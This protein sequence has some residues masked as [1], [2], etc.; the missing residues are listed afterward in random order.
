MAGGAPFTNLDPPTAADLQRSGFDLHELDQ[1]MEHLLTYI[2]I[3]LIPNFPV[4]DDRR[5]TA[6][7][8]PD[9]LDRISR[10]PSPDAARTAALSSRWRT[11][12]RSA[13]PDLIDAHLRP[14]DYFWPPAP[15]NSPA[16][17]ATVSRILEAHPGPFRRVHLVCSH[18]N[19]YQPQLARWLQL[20][21]AK[22]VQDLVL[23]NRPWP[24]DVPLPGALF[25][26]NTLVR[27]YIGLWKLPDTARLGRYRTF[28]H[29]R[30]LGIC[31]VVMGE[32]D[33]DSI[34]ARCPVLEI[35]SIQ[36]SSK[37]L[38]LRLVSQSLRCVQICSSVVENIAVV[39]A[40]SLERLILHG[41]RDMP[42]GLSSRVRILDAPKLRALGVLEPTNHVLEIG[43]K[44]I[45]AGIKTNTSTIL[46]SVK[47]LSLN[48]RFGVRSEAEMVPTFLKCF[49]NVKRLHIMNGRNY[50]VPNIFHLGVSNDNISGLATVLQ[51]LQLMPFRASRSPMFRVTTNV[52]GPL[53]LL[54]F[55]FCTI[56]A[57]EPTSTTRARVSFA[58]AFSSTSRDPMRSETENSCLLCFREVA[59]VPHEGGSL[60]MMPPATNLSGSRSP[61]GLPLVAA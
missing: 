57:A 40:P 54:K 26:V 13:Q 43:D 6:L 50:T 49:P 36:G 48:V 5:L 56:W 52:A 51:L 12:W 45:R 34:V 22:G 28:P 17:T 21:A 58:L 27:L 44:I 2:C 59:K 53:L 61:S 39:K 25:A 47:I 8:A 19:G 38:R 46:T 60:A 14:D 33:V 15:A 37:G 31:C 35:L 42:F 11:I 3:N 29:L 10:L 32:G 18:M 9:G 4:P 16:I 7:P 55:F 1:A 23:V 20:L 24:C 30:E 41:C